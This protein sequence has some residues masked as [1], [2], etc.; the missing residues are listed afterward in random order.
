MKSD[1]LSYRRA[2]VEDIDVLTDMRMRFIEEFSG[3]L[4]PK[5]RDE[6]EGEI[7][8]YLKTAIPEDEFIAY[9]AEDDGEA[10]GIGGMVVWQTPPGITS[11]KIGYILSMFTVP[12]MRGEGLGTEMLERLIDDGKK[13][14]LKYIHLHATKDG[15]GI[16]RRA[17]F[18]EPEN[19]ELKLRLY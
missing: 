9:I 13:A 4:N 15:E 14:G 2:T 17:G 7:K 3:K 19:I 1:E 12:E 6:L 10:V 16:Y 11:G 8:K 5:R 18:K